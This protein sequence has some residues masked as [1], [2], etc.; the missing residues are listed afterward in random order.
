MAEYENPPFV[1][2][3]LPFGLD[4]STEEPQRGV[5]PNLSSSAV[6]CEKGSTTNQSSTC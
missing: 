3:Y 6:C 5:A 2:I 1:C 4:F